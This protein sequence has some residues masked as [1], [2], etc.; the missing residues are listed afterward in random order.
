VFTL[1][2]SDRCGRPVTVVGIRKAGVEAQT[3][4]RGLDAA[5]S[6]S[7]V[8]VTERRSAE[9]IGR[10]RRDASGRRCLRLRL[11]SLGASGPASA[12]EERD[13]DEQDDEARDARQEN[14]RGKRGQP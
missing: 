4:E 7:A 14:G 10:G 6:G 5:H 1:E 12:T 2:G 8:T 11:G 13:R 3:G 9:Q